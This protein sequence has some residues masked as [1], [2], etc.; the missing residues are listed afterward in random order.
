MALGNEV[1]NWTWWVRF[2]KKTRGWKFCETITLREPQFCLLC[3]QSC[4]RPKILA[5]FSQDSRELKLV[6]ILASLATKF[7]FARL[8]RSE[9]HYKIWLR[10]SREP[11]LAMKFLSVRL[12]RSESCY[13]ICLREVSLQ[14]FC[15]LDSREASLVTNF[16]SQLS[17]ESR[18]NFGSI[19]RVPL[20]R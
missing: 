8:V 1:L 2:V 11:S 12:V 6:L 5:R 9:S 10:D 14:N 15:L 16:N 18:K 17:R 7:L 20:L 4:V 13:E 19:R 3:C